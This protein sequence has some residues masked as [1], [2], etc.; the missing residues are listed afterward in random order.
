MDKRKEA[1][2]RV[3]NSITQTVLRLLDKK[4]SLKSLF[5]KSSGKPVWQGLPFTETTPP[6]KASSPH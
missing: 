2:L 4:V 5:L 6:K 3:K 1:N